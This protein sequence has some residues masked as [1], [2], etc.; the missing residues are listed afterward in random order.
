MKKYLLLFFLLVFSISCSNTFDKNRIKLNEKNEKTLEVTYC[1]YES[2]I[3]IEKYCT[4]QETIDLFKQLPR[5]DGSFL[6]I[7]FAKMQI[8]HFSWNKQ[9]RLCLAEITNVDEESTSSQRY[10]TFQESIDL[11]RSTFAG[12]LMKSPGF[13]SVPVTTMTLDNALMEMQDRQE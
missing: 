11:I 3:F 12:K 9:K 8:I 13:V 6:T 5:T 10:A 4:E 7:G 2:D 1:N